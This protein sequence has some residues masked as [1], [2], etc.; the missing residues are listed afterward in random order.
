MRLCVHLKVTRCEE[1]Q[2]KLACRVYAAV[3]Q[4]ESNSHGGMLKCACM[5]FPSLTFPRQIM[6]N[7]Y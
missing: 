5:A 4:S 3:L 1:K 2:Q 7:H 6:S